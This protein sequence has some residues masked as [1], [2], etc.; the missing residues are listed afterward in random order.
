MGSRV[1][2]TY[3]AACPSYCVPIPYPDHWSLTVPRVRQEYLCAGLLRNRSSIFGDPPGRCSRAARLRVALR[4][5]RMLSF[6]RPEFSMNPLSKSPWP[7]RSQGSRTSQPKA[8]TQQHA[9]RCGHS[10]QSCD[11]SGF[12]KCSLRYFCTSARTAAPA[13]TA[14]SVSNGF[15]T[16]HVESRC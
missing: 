3:V 7:R 6:R 11:Y 8:S 9:F 1:I 12:G 13:S 14:A 4:V 10:F 5:R 2:A 15:R 16:P